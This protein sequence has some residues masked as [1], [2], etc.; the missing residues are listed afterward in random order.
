MTHYGKIIM[1]FIVALAAA[2]AQSQS[3]SELTLEECLKIG[4]ESNKTLQVS[5][6]KID[7][8]SLK[9]EETEAQGL[10]SL[11]FTGVYTRL[12]EIDP[13]TMYGFT[14]SPSIPNQYILKFTASQPIFT[15]FRIQN[16]EE[17]LDYQLQAT[18]TD[19]QKDEKQLV[20]DIKT[21]FW[22]FYKSVEMKK[23][24]D[25]SIVQVKAHLKDIESFYKNGL[26]TLND[27]LKVQV[28]LSN[29]ELNK[30]DMENA[31]ELSN[32]ALNNAMGISVTERYKINADNSIP[33]NKYTDLNNSIQTAYEG[34]NELQSME[35]RLKAGEKSI[36]MAKAGWY[37]QVFASANY[38]YN[39]PN[40]RIFPQKEEFKGTWD[41]GI[42][43]S[44]DIWNWN[45]TSLQV[46]QA[47]VNQAQSELGLQQMKDG[48]ALEVTQAY[49]TLSKS[50]EKIGVSEKAVK[51]AEE[52]LRVTNEKFKAGS[53]INSDLLDA[54]TALLLAKINYTTAVVDYKLAFAKIERATGN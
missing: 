48:I 43:A 51:Q 33:E 7:Y 4:R 42:S 12:S 53:L 34:R 8:T 2:S 18:Q 27:V 32:A 49:L 36:E 5:R 28:Q 41:I 24:I 26:V 23:S 40:S 50:K 10:P 47:E 11:K 6:K 17:M 13:V 16:S 19:L 45:T 15:G 31:I 38:N 22:N 14:L 9:L 39:N 21:A 25:E 37:P 3:Y 44:W 46:Q 35:L 30:I 52:N 20:V 29:L 1:I 54:E